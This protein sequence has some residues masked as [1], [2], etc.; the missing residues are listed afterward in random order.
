MIKIIVI[1]LSVFMTATTL[2]TESQ[3]HMKYSVLAIEYVGVSDK[4]I[5]PIVVSDSEAGAEWYRSAVLKRDKLDLTNVHVVNA[6]L[7]EKLIAKLFER[8]AQQKQEKISKS[9][10]AVSVTI[11]TPQQRNSFMFDTESAISS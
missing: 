2:A 3:K 4:S 1:F 11:I 6:V 10:K 7:L 8:S 9:A 5:T